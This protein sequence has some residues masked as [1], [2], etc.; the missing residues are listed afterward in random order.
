MAVVD[1]EKVEKVEAAGDD[2]PERASEGR[3]GG[4]AGVL[5]WP[6]RKLAEGRAFFSEVRSELKKVTWPS[7]KEVYSTISLTVPEPTVR[8]PS[9]IAKR[10][11]FSIAIGVISS[12]AISTL[13]P[14]ITISRPSGSVATPVTSVVRK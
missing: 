1:E 6:G 10:S 12:T 2:K 7:R 8:P 9:R 13:S 14:G 5:G 3:P 11:P 4:L